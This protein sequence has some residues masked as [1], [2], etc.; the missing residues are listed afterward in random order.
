MTAKS[1]PYLQILRKEVTID[2]ILHGISMS[3]HR[4]VTRVIF[5]GEWRLDGGHQIRHLEGINSPEEEK[6][7]NL[8]STKSA[9]WIHK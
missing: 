1:K 2:T 8:L 4:P 3:E 9:V 5:K 7:I 6:L